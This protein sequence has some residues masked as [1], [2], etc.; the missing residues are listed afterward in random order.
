VTRRWLEQAYGDGP[1]RLRVIGDVSCDV[2]GSIE[3][4]VKTTDS[5]SPY[6]V[7]DP[8]AGTARDGVEGRG[9]VIMA[10][11]NL[12]CEL[13]LG[14]SREFGVALMPFVPVL[15]GTDFARPLEEL[16]LPPEIR[17][18]LIL[19]RGR[20]TP[21]FAYIERYLGPERRGRG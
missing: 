10:V 5:G 16:G 13:P 9:P 3:A 1:P 19:H 8:A 11:D 7:F 4:T 14:S 15:A 6:Y 17:R 21:E 18:G 20:L 12:P 2:E